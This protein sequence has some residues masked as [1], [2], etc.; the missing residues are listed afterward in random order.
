MP[1]GKEYTEE[2]TGTKKNILIFLFRKLSGST[3]RSNKIPAQLVVKAPGREA[4]HATS[5]EV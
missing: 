1:D 2:H 4:V 3:A 5:L